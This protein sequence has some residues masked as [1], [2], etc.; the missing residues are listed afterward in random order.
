MTQAGTTPS[1][2]ATAPSTSTTLSRPIAQVMPRF[3]AMA[4][5]VAAI[6]FLPAGTLRWWQGWLFLA[7]YMSSGLGL[8]F[9][10][11][12]ADP[13]LVNR[14]LETKEQAPVQKLLI[15]LAAPILMGIFMLPGFDRRFGWSKRLWGPEPTWL[16]V[17]SLAMTLAAML[18][19][20]WVMWT[21]QYAART[22][23]VEQGQTVITTG[24][25]RLVRHPMYAFCILMFVF[26]LLAL[27]SYVS[28]PALVLF[29][30]IFVLRILNEEKVLGAELPGYTEYSEKTRYRLVPLV[31]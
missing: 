3:V 23:R 22:I 11:V 18:A 25:Y 12:K 7:T 26:A 10:F 5:V 14:R 21:N 9:F 17:L 8:F 24:P 30:P 13:Q 27:G 31:W 6:L 28:L 1:P 16:Q 2:S 29:A 15:G 20:A 4:A 19:T